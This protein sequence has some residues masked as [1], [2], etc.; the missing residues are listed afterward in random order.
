MI[1]RRDAEAIMIKEKVSHEHWCFWIGG[2][3]ET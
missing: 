1:F 2:K 3:N